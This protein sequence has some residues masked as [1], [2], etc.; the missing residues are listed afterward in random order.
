MELRTLEY[1]AAFLLFL[2]IIRPFV[3][4]LWKLPGL[5]VFPLLA[6]GIIIGIFPSYGFRPECIPLLLF[7]V[8]LVYA[9]LLDMAA[10]FSGLQGN[11]YRERGLLFTFGSVALFAFTL[12]FTV[13]YGPPLD[14]EFSAEG[15]T[16]VFLQ[17]ETLHVRIYGP[18]KPGMPEDQPAETM[19]DAARAGQGRPLLILLPPVSGSFTVTDEVCTALRDRGFTVIS[20]SRLHFDSPF[21]DQNGMPVRLFISDLYR[22]IDAR[23]HGLSNTTANERGRK[24]EEVRKQDTLFILQELSRNGALKKLLD[25]ADSGTVF[26]AGYGVGGSAL[27][28]LAGQD[29]VITRFPQ[30]RGVIAIEAPLLSSLE[31]DEPPSPP[32][33]PLDPISAF[34]QRT[35]E[36]VDGLFPKKIT[37][38][39]KIPKP[40]LPIMFILSD[41]VIRERTGRYATILRALD[42][43]QNMALLA[44][45]P[46][47]GPFDYSGSPTYYPAISFLFRGAENVE[48]SEKKNWPELTASL[49]AN[50]AAFVLEN[51]VMEPEDPDTPGEP[52]KPGA[53]RLVK[54]ALAG[55]IH[56]EQGGVWQNSE[57][58][59]ILQP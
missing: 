38:I 19:P 51:E 22:L 58:R 27:T 47:A 16:A 23:L 42:A 21:L 10:L 39:G 14:A 59:T 36:L 32:P 56:L 8:F 43:S 48:L 45:V 17:E 52:G 9:N 30:I 5:T 18:V 11:F 29:N 49:I 57:G 55:N 33:M 26:L 50:F 28:V 31:G 20:F 53:A 1:L 4:G 6:L 3:R 7:A 40:V 15:V 12:W 2:S 35:G 24:L 44:A 34:Y 46:G 13:H 37:H 54:T 41:R 25:G